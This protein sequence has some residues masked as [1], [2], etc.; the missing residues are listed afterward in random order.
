MW[1]GLA[2]YRRVTA[3]GF[4]DGPQIT[5]IM[6]ARELRGAQLGGCGCP[7]MP[8]GRGLAGA[9]RLAYGRLR[10][11]NWLVSCGV[12]RQ[13][14]CPTLTGVEGLPLVGV[15]VRTLDGLRAYPRRVM[16]VRRL[17]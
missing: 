13:V 2:G 11:R 5:L 8:G 3:S 16:K 9:D 14:G 10:G 4:S 1:R 6:G 15:R 12:P 7:A 17:R